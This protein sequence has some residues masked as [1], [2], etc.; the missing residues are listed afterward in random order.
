MTDCASCGR[1][2]RRDHELMA[3]RPMWFDRQLRPICVSCANALL[4]D[5]PAR[6]IAFTK[7]GRYEV[8]TDH[9]VLDHHWDDGPPICFETMIFA[10]D[11]AD[12][13]HTQCWRY[14]T[15]AAALAGHDQVL[16]MLRESVPS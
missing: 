6:R 5:G 11:H 3:G 2:L 15:E 8:C 12:P 1:T 4:G 16:A 7:I 10:E 14:P 13:L 9:L